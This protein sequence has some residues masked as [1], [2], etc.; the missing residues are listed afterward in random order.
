M[1]R[2]CAGLVMLSLI[3]VAA[4]N[5][6][7]QPTGGAP[8]K[9]GTFTLEDTKAITMKQGT[10]KD[11]TFTIDRQPNFT[12]P[13]TLTFKTKKGITFTPAKAEIPPNEGNKK[14]KGSAT[15]K[16]AVTK[17][18]PVGKQEIMVVA[19]PKNGTPIEK[20]LDITVDNP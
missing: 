17:E 10:E 2:L 18:A 5:N 16:I 13:V 12:Q 11:Y 14:G 3:A 19:T 7:P 15:V 9:G 1:K 20:P 8:G 6:K 4:C